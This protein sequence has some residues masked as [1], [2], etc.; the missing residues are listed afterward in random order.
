MRNFS[1]K[2]CRENKNTFYVEKLFSGN[3]AVYDIMSKN[4]VEPERSWIKI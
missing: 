1:D 2:S 3:H 4:V